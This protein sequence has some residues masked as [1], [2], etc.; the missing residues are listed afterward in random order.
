MDFSLAVST[1]TAKFNSPSIFTVHSSTCTKFGELMSSLV[2][3]CF[4]R[5]LMCVRSSSVQQ[6]IPVGIIIMCVCV[7]GGGGG[8]E[9]PL[10]P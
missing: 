3:S 10:K 5:S 9:L 6:N 2:W 8:G 7:C 4:I 1:L